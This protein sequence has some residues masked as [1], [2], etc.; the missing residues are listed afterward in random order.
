MLDTTK[1]NTVSLNVSPNISKTITKEPEPEISQ[2]AQNAFALLRQL[3]QQVEREKKGKLY[4]KPK[5]E[6]DLQS[7]ES[8]QSANSFSSEESGGFDVERKKKKHNSDTSSKRDAEQIFEYEDL[9]EIAK[10]TKRR[11]KLQK[12]LTQ[13]RAETNDY[14]QC[15]KFLKIGIVATKYNWSDRK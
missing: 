4:E 11:R 9:Q 6:E 10:I 12:I 5:S 15:T 1:S 2:K 14:M 7:N 8:F 3:K 13:P